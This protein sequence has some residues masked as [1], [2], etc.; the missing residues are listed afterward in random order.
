MGLTLN[1]YA[2]ARLD[3]N[4]PVASATEEKIYGVLG[5]DWIPPE[6]RENAGEIDAAAEH[7]LPK[8][9]ELAIFAVTCTCTL[10]KS[11]GRA[12]A[13]GDGGAARERGLDYIAITDHSK[14]LAMTNGLD[15]KASGG[16]R[17][18]RFEKWVVVKTIGANW[19]CACSPGWSATSCATGKWICRMTH[20][21]A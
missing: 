1:E 21:G 17:A 10:P 14:S 19:R 12:D 9:V 6:L 7:R 16:V 13:G 5:L 11:D 2:L 8:L 20:G 3:D 18:I 15:E 4:T